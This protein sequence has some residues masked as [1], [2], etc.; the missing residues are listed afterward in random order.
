MW[1]LTDATGSLL[2]SEKA[3][4]E[5]YK[6]IVGATLTQP[7]SRDKSGTWTCFLLRPGGYEGEILWN[8]NACLTIQAR[9]QMVDYRDLNGAIHSILNRNISVQYLPIL[10]NS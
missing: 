3:Y 6:W 10:R 9:P 4:G 2:A 1:C 8:S 5:S 7:C